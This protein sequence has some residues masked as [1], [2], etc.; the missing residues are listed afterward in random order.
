MYNKI[1]V[2]LDAYQ[3]C[4]GDWVPLAY[5]SGI[6]KKARSNSTRW[7]K[8]EHVEVC[9]VG[10]EAND[11]YKILLGHEFKS[12]LDNDEMMPCMRYFSISNYRERKE[13]TL[14]SCNEI[15]CKVKSQKTLLI[16]W[17]VEPGI[18]IIS[19]PVY[20]SG[21]RAKKLIRMLTGHRYKMHNDD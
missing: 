10:Q 17:E 12:P 15:V 9:V 6:S 20:L 1:K 7:H 19:G 14:K 21:R 8:S 5:A 16:V 2:T 18:G 4:N 13:S 11:W 3:D